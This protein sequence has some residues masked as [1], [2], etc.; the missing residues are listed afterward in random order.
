MVGRISEL[1]GGV[2]SDAGRGADRARS[3][4]HRV[5]YWRCLLVVLVGGHF[6]RHF[7]RGCCPD[8][9][10]LGAATTIALIVVG[11]MLGSL[12]FD[13]FGVLGIQA[14]PASLV[15]MAGAG[16]LILGVVLIRA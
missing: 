9:S 12:A 13:H 5:V 6:R 10:R 11:Q 8:G 7:H 16:C 15:R 14:H 1:S 4:I 2:N 3:A